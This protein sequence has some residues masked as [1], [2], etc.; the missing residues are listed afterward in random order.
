MAM[1]MPPSPIPAPSS[2]QRLPRDLARAKSPLRTFC[3]KVW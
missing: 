1:A 3:G 2:M